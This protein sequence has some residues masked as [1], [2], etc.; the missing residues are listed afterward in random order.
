MGEAEA[1]CA[2]EIPHEDDVV[3]E[4]HATLTPVFDE[5]AARKAAVTDLMLTNRSTEVFA[6]SFVKKFTVNDAVEIWVRAA[7]DQFERT[8]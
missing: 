3:I 4:T 6:A 8:K 5:M 7:R 2:L 1:Y